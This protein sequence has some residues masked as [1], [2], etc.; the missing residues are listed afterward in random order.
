[1][2]QSGK[3]YKIIPILLACPM[4]PLANFAVDLIEKTYK[5]VTSIL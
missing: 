1:M 3:I 2:G 5:I 4:F